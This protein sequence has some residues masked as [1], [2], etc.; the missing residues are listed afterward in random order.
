MPF[1]ARW[2]K[3]L[4]SPRGS[5][6]S[7]DRQVRGR[8]ELPEGGMPNLL[9]P[10]LGGEGTREKPR[11][12]TGTAGRGPPD[13]DRKDGDQCHRSGARPRLEDSGQSPA[14]RSSRPASPSCLAAEPIGSV[15]AVRPGPARAVSALLDPSLRG[16]PRSG[17]H[18]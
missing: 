4:T 12:S 17:I 3:N 6:S 18:R 2:D 13:D 14:A 16:D 8:T 5:V 7:R 1:M 15:Q 11:P 9:T 10:A